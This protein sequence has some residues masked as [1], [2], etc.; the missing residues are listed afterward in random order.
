MP[1]QLEFSA[2]PSTVRAAQRL[3]ELLKRKRPHLS[4]QVGELQI[5]V[6]GAHRTLHEWS[7]VCPGA[8]EGSWPV[9]QTL[10]PLRGKE[11]ALA[12][13]DLDTAYQALLDLRHA[14]KPTNKA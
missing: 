1:N 8:Q 5:T 9:A 2:Y 3:A 10:D 4:A 6:T 14:D 13:T 7:L 12:L 11:A